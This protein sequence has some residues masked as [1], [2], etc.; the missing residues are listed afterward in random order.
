MVVGE[1]RA[2]AECCV[3]V[4]PVYI[5]ESKWLDGSVVFLFI[6]VDFLTWKRSRVGLVNEAYLR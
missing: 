6:R 5:L 2:L 3:D 4:L 1:R